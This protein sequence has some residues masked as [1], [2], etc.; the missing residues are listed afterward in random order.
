MLGRC[1]CAAVTITA[2]DTREVHACHCSLCRRWGGGP[3]LS[4]HA[5]RDV[6]FDGLA[7]VTAYASSDWA[8][9]LFCSRCGTHLAWR[10]KD[11]GEYALP[12]GLFDGA[13][14]ELSSQ[15]FVD[16]KP[17]WYDFANDTERLTEA[18]VLARYMG[19]AAG[20]AAPD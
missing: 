5:G 1:L 15:I 12:A 6:R 8:D 16:H 10:M 9:R 13:A 18:E 7:H 20:P 11:S 3:L 17:G 2:P 14:F 4:L 19:D